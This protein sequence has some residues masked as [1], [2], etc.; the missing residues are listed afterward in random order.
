MEG[1]SGMNS[2]PRSCNR[3]EASRQMASRVNILDHEEIMDEAERRDRLDYDISEDE[4]ESD[5]GESES[6]V[7]SD[8]YE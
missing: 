8:G 7:E 4:D 1:I 6:E 3:V 5:E 2:L